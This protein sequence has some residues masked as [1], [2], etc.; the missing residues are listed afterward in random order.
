MADVTDKGMGKTSEAGDSE[1]GEL[2]PDRDM[3]VESVSFQ[4]LSHSCTSDSTFLSSALPNNLRTTPPPPPS[5][6][7]SS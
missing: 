2:F 5:S 1:G 7:L 4:S 3:G 6:S